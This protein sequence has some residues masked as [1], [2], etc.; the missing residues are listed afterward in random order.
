[1]TTTDLSALSNAEIDRRIA[2]EV[3]GENQPSDDDPISRQAWIY[4]KR[5]TT[6]Y[7]LP[8]STSYDA[9]HTAWAK[10]TEEQKLEVAR[11]GRD[12]RKRTLMA[13]VDALNATPREL[14]LWILAAV[15][16]CRTEKK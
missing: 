5:G 16:R 8:F 10:L 14:C 7:P 9:A 6:R 1:M 4:Y 12:S 11:L 3:F 13:F 2:E 15:E